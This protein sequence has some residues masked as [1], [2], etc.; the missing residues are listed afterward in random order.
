MKRIL[1]N[2][3]LDIVIAV[4]LNGVLLWQS[5]YSQQVTSTQ[6]V[7]LRVM[8]LNK[9][10]LVGGPLTLQ[11]NSIN[12]NA[13]EPNPAVDASTKLLWT[14]NGDA[15]KIAVG[16]DI[17]SP[18]FILKIEAEKSG[19]GAGIAQPEVTLSDNSPHD[20]ILGVQRSAG[21]CSLRF[22]ALASAEEGTG[23]ESHLITYTITGG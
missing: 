12:D 9:I 14:S 22:K 20:L 3:A 1:K 6:V 16:S 2:I 5:V 11:I 17:A 8:E 15:R 13:G 10:D 21:S 23:S 19:S 4:T 18:R 7:T